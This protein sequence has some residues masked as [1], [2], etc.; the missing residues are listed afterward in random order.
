MWRTG[1]SLIKKKM[2]ETG[3]LLAGEL[4]GHIMIADDYYGFDDALYCAC[5]LIDLAGRMESSLSE[6]VAEFPAYVST[7]ELRIEVT[8]ERKWSIVD[9]AL[10]HFRSLYDVIDVDGVR[11]L[12]GDGW[13]LLRVSNTQPVI[14]A[15]FE[16]KTEARLD[17][18]RADVG[19]W[20]GTQGVTL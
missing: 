3:A 12:F 16:A 2:K 10:E 8:E 18:I 17:E 6:A 13:A 4:S 7:P 19:A 14:V 5:R 15:R 1:H 20:L 11:I 9:A